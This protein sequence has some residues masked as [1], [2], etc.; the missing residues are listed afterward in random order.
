MRAF[1]EAGMTDSSKRLGE[2][3]DMSVIVQAL[4]RVDGLPLLLPEI[5]R[6]LDS[7]GILSEILVL[8]HHSDGQTKALASEH[9][10]L[11][12]S[13]RHGAHIC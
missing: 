2:A 7:L 13:P 3:V 10:A 12:R 4:S 8:V 6:E 9:G 5:R 1:R 11:Q